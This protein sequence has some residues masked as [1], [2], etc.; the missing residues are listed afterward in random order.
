MG[1]VS[2]FLTAGAPTLFYTSRSLAGRTREKYCAGMV[3]TQETFAFVVPVEIFIVIV[4]DNKK[5]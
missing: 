3:A 4:D 1:V 5:R 2:L